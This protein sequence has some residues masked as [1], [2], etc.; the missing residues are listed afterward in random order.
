MEDWANL[1]NLPKE[2]PSEHKVDLNSPSVGS[3]LGK[4]ES[5]VLES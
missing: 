2:N 1:L 4:K 5:I 3:V